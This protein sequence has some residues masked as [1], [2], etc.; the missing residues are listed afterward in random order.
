M[1]ENLTNWIKS[2]IKQDI[3]LTQTEIRNQARKFSGDI[4]FKASKGWLEKYFRRNKMISD[5][6]NYLLTT[7]RLKIQ[8]MKRDEDI[9]C[10]NEEME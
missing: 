1:E 7:K 3:Y 10:K 6:L 8:V 5:G 4:N 2:K 9:E